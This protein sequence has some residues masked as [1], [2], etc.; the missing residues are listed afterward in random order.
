M[1][2]TPTTGPQPSPGKSIGDG[3]GRR[4]CR[5]GALATHGLLQPSGEVTDAGDAGRCPCM[6]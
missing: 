1:A 3:W 2:S 4:T 5:G 6:V